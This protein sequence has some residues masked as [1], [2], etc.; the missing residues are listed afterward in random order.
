[1]SKK[2]F[3]QAERETLSENPYISRVSEKSLAYTD[4]FKRLFIDQYL[5]GKT[6]REI[7]ETA[8]FDVSLIGYY[9]YLQTA[10]VRIK[11]A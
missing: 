11:R 10:D 6:P 5:S 9:H 7:F 4:E 8:G 2:H 1:M 3:N